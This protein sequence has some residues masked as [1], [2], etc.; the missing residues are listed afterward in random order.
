MHDTSINNTAKT[1]VVAYA[2]LVSMAMIGTC[3]FVLLSSPSLP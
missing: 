1:S 2:F 3:L